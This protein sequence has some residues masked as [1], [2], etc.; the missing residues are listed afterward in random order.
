MLDMVFL[1]LN[2][3]FNVIFQCFKQHDQ[4]EY[5]ILI[6][7]SPEHMYADISD[8]KMIMLKNVSHDKHVEL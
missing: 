8:G 6:V 7:S 2:V 3:T 1:F 4:N 5:H